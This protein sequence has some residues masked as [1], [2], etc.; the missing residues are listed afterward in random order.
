MDDPAAAKAVAADLDQSS[1]IGV[2]S[3][4]AFVINGYPLLG[5]QPLTEF[6]NLIDTVQTLS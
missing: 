5:A 4:P 3:T 1:T 6:T 2:P